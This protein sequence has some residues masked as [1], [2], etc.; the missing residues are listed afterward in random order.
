[1]AAPQRPVIYKLLKVASIAFS[2]LLFSTT[3]LKAA[4]RIYATYGAFERSVAIDKIEKFALTGEIDGL[5]ADYPCF[6]TLGK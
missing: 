5:L 1:M 3:E 6:V 4:E 2:L